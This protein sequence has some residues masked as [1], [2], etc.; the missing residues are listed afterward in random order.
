MTDSVLNEIFTENLQYLPRWNTALANHLPM[1]AA[2]MFLLRQ[3]SAIS[4]AHIR[5]NAQDYAKQLTPRRTND[6]AMVLADMPWSMQASL[7][8]NDDVFESW[9]LFFQ[10][11]L[12]ADIDG[13]IKLWLARLGGGLCGA[14]GHSLIRLYYSL[15]VRGALTPDTFVREISI[16]LADFA[17]RH[18]TLTAMEEVSGT[19]RLEAFLDDH[20]P[21]DRQAFGIIKSGALIEDRFLLARASDGFQLAA[22][23]VSP[24]YDLLGVLRRLAAHVPKSS[25][26]TLLHALTVGHALSEIEVIYPDVDNGLMRQAYRDYVIATVL[27]TGLGNSPP[28]ADAGVTLDHLLER[29]PLLNNDHAQKATY[30]LY[31]LYERSSAQEFLEAAAVFQRT[32]E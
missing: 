22:S 3:Q 18:T 15:A 20:E 17:T 16:T 21:L 12:C 31:R 2:A 13:V 9:E 5:E 4:L 19:R 8:G 30:S 27:S 24:D 23:D 26:F 6:A 10:Q 25:N 29:V 14:G 32:L 28:S 7:L 11:Q 1:A